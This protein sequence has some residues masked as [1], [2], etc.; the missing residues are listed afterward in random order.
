[1]ADPLRVGVIGCG[2]FA[3]NHLHSWK[4]LAGEGASLT[5]VCDINPAKAKAAAETFGAQHWYSDVDRMLAAEKLDLVDIV[6]RVETHEEMVGRTIAARI[7]TIVQK[8]FGPDLAASEAMAKAAAA[9]GVFLAVHENFRFQAPFRRI[10]AL[11]RAGAI[12][13]PS[14][15]RISFR[16]AYD[17]YR[18]QPYLLREERFI[19]ID[20]GV[21]VLDLA[22]VF[23]GEVAHLSAETQRRDP[24]VAGEDTATMLLRH[25]G[26][27]VHP[28]RGSDNSARAAAPQRAWR[29][30]ERNR[31]PSLDLVVAHC[32][33]TGSA[34]PERPGRCSR[35]ASSASAALASAGARPDKDRPVAFS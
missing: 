29:A 24:R 15:A 35:W 9:A 20:L 26:G 21:H 34:A 28:S 25:R 14:W 8:P 10:A 5:A 31:R 16:T 3:Q 4:S 33:P 11:L 6:T 19:L 2:F 22:R 23:L 13:Q 32:D 18:T 30:S 12:G 7:P 17:I 1:M 27:G